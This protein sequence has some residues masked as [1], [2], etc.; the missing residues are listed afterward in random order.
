MDPSNGE[1]DVIIVGAGTAGCVVAERLSR[2]P[3]VR[4]LLIESGPS[5]P[6]APADLF[7]ALSAPGRLW[8]DVTARR[9]P[10]GPVRVY[11]RGRGIGG[12]G[13][14]NGLLDLRP[15]GGDLDRWASVGLALDTSVQRTV[16]Q[17]PTSKW[18]PADRVLA[19]AGHAAGLPLI[20]R[21]RVDQA[22][23][24]AAP[25]H[26]RFDVDRQLLRASTDV[27][28]LGP[29]RQRPNLAD[30]PLIAVTA[31]AMKGDRQKCLDAGAS[32]YIAKP[33]DIDLLLALLRVWVGRSHAEP[34][35]LVSTKAAR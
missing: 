17:L 4:V 3:A 34:Q 21:A 5:G 11:P 26:A 22:G 33:V 20:R 35:P 8:P 6:T 16:A 23:I 1:W 32:D 2:D 24:G 19:T 27:T 31:K 9:S 12:S 28:H 18:G 7:G 29:A 10:L 30:L 14:V 25:L 15:T 13:A